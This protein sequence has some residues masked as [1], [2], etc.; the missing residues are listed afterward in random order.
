LTVESH[1]VALTATDTDGE[2]C[3]AAISL[4]INGQPTAPVVVIAPGPAFTAD[5]LSAVII[6]ASTDPEGDPIT[7]TYA[8]TFDGTPVA[9]TDATILA[10]E[11]IKGELWQVTVTPT[12]VLLAG[13]SATTDREISNTP[14]QV[15]LA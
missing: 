11:T 8:W 13:E 15:L 5:D 3:E 1:T 14:P 4:S 12:D 6:T 9:T 10:S 7:Y 2:T